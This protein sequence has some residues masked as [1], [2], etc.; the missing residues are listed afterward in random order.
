MAKMESKFDCS[1]MKGLREETQAYLRWSIELLL[2]F[3]FIHAAYDPFFGFRCVFVLLCYS[4]LNI[5]DT[6]TEGL[7]S[8]YGCKF[9][10]LWLESVKSIAYFE[11][12]ALVCRAYKIA[13]IRDK[14]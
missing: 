7:E 2:R 3:F 1:V 6:R 9:L 10:K 12:K 8:K 4:H 14:F 13:I 11:R 5:V